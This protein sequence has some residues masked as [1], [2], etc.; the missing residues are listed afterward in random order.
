MCWLPLACFANIYNVCSEYV[1]VFILMV[2]VGGIRLPCCHAIFLIQSMTDYRLQCHSVLSFGILREKKIG[3]IK[4]NV[5]HLFWNLFCSTKLNLPRMTYLPSIICS[6]WVNAIRSPWE[7]NAT[8]PY[9]ERKS[10]EMSLNWQEKKKKQKKN[11]GRNTS[12]KHI[13]SMS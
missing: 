1:K 7:L 8:T 13:E 12:Q 9:W 2:L 4:K 5:L 6:I 10:F 11:A 3:L